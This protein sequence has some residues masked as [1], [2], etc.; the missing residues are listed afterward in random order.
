MWRINRKLQERVAFEEL[1]SELALLGNTKIKLADYLHHC[2]ERMGVHLQVSRAWIMEHDHTNDTLTNTVEWCAPNIESQK[3]TLINFPASKVPWWTEKMKSGETLAFQDVADIPDDIA[4]E[5]IIRQGISSVL[6][7]PFFIS[8]TYYGFAGFDVCHRTRSW[9]KADRDMLT[10]ISRLICN[11]IGRV[12][13]EEAHKHQTEFQKMATETAADFL[14]ADLT[15]IDRK[16]NDTLARMGRFF[17]VDRSYLFQLNEDRTTFTNTHEWCAPD[18]SSEMDDIQNVSFENFPWWGAQMLSENTVAIHHLD[19]MPPE[20]EN[21]KKELR[22]QNIQSWM[23]VPIRADSRLLGHFGFDAVKAPRTWPPTLL[24]QLQVISTIFADALCKQEKDG[25]LHQAMED[26]KLASQ[27]KSEFLANMSHEIRTPMNGIIGMNDLLLST[28]LGGEQRRYAE[29]MRNSGEALLTLVNDLL[30]LSKIESGKLQLVREPLDLLAILENLIAGLTPTATQKGLELSLDLAPDLP[31]RVLGDAGRIRQI[32]LNLAGNAIKFTPHGKVLIAVRGAGTPANFRLRFSVRDTGIGIPDDNQHLLF[33]KF[34][35]V[36][37]SSTRIYGGTGLG[38]AICRELVE[39]M[40]GSVGVESE[41]GSGSEFWFEIP[42]GIPD[43]NTAPPASDAKRNRLETFSPKDLPANFREYPARI[44]LVEDNLTN[45]MVALRILEKIGLRAETAKDGFEA[46]ELTRQ[47]TYDLILM[48]VQ[49]PGMDGLEA[50][51]KL[52]RRGSRIPIVAMTA[53]AMKEDRQLC[54]DAGMNDYLSKPVSPRT[55][56]HVLTK[57][58]PKTPAGPPTYDSSSLTEMLL[59]DQRL[60]NQI[61]E[62]FLE[63]MGLQLNELRV[64]MNQAK[65]IQAER[66]AHS[67]KSAAAYVGAVRFSQL[68][69]RI[70]ARLQSG[71]PQGLEPRI[72]ELEAAFREVRA[73]MLR[74]L[75]V[76]PSL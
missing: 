55:L 14:N 43:P 51:R 32:L 31:K 19:E 40:G 44:L 4:R 60:I 1:L 56:I 62:G 10:A 45:R 9:S 61:Q 72:E 33:E 76:S 13:A 46:L 36:D 75:D 26:A 20:A 53:H 27:A 69:A 54:I 71:H 47:Q 39:R 41:E 15:N 11:V 18:I 63:D 28:E 29:I 8:G 25:A 21:E 5:Q 30:D 73:L 65:F 48:D 68:A 37:A 38:L 34:Y 12:E 70:E 23:I 52:R 59:G 74:E 16:I 66:I 24:D 3:D 35:Q 49:M 7:V 42:A 64:S 50:T 57:W 67:I 2:M 6:A 17:Q 22:R 58:L